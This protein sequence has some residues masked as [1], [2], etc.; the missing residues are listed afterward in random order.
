MPGVKRQKNYKYYPKQS[1][2]DSVWH[3]SPIRYMVGGVPRVPG[4]Y[5]RPHLRANWK[6][7]GTPHNLPSTYESQASK[8]KITK[9]KNRI[10]AKIYQ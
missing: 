3:L 10:A 1:P 6:A 7:L 9:A 8:N 5:G 2:Q 4:Q